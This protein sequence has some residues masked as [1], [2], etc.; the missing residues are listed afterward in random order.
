VPVRA[1]HSL[2]RALKAWVLARGRSPV[3]AFAL[4]PIFLRRMRQ[5]VQHPELPSFPY[6]FTEHASVSAEDV[7]L[8][9]RL[10][11]FWHSMMDRERTTRWS[12]DRDIWTPII[13]R[14]SGVVRALEQRDAAAVA[15][16]LTDAPTTT[17]C[18]G[19]LQGDLDTRSLHRN[20]A[21]RALKARLTVDRFVSLMEAIGVL[22]VRNPEQSSSAEAAE[23]DPIVLL[24]EL[25]AH[26]GTEALQAQVFG[27]LFVSYVGGRPFNQ[28]DVMAMHA[29]LRLRTILSSVP[30]RWVL[31]FGGGSGRTAYWCLR[32]GLGP[33][34][35]IDLPHV[36]VLQAWYL[37]KALPAND[38]WLYGESPR[39]V[40]AAAYLFPD[41]A[42]DDLSEDIALAFNQDSLPEMSEAAASRYLAWIVRT[43]ARWLLSVNHESAP[44][45]A[46]DAFQ[47]D[48]ARLIR[49]SSGLTLIERQRNWIRSGYIDGLY[50]VNDHR[51][52]L[53][54]SVR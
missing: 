26:C 28:V 34:Q 3:I 40:R 5:Q 43:K 8:A 39:P 42:I 2:L 13:A 38:I 45:Y 19:I 54:A 36:A 24:R 44:A 52:D 11:A 51:R 35:I 22:P 53:D 31:E 6:G 32:F 29:A 1:V 18:Q 10:V 7:A 46:A 15:E 21:Y 16:Y 49:R 47:L 20:A 50:A 12:R 9:E 14:Q 25:D 33:V 17:M 23:A 37:I 30:V 27:G 48:P 4:T 41:S